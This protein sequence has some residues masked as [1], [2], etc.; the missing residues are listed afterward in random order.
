MEKFNQRSD[1]ELVQLYSK[2]DNLAFDLLVHR[3]KNKIHTYISYIVRDLE[4]TEDLFQETFIKAILTIR[5]GRYTETGRFGAWLTRIAHNLIIDHYRQ[6]K[7]TQVVSS[8]T[9]GFDILNDPKL[10]EKNIED[11]LITDQITR[12][13]RM[14]IRH[15]PTNQKEVLVMRYYQNLSFKEIADITGV[16]I[17]TALGR[18]RYALIN[19]RRMA[20]ENKI[21][22]SVY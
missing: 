5:Q 8:D 11:H 16:S 12:D 1:E 6:E 18:M 3:Y 19:I 20:D 10:S 22:L 15:L 9:E 4:L 21:S 17:N 2:G 7:S 13:V 14:L